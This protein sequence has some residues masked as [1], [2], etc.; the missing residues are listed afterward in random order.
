MENGT[1]N[2][3]SQGTINQGTKAG[4]IISINIFS[5][6]NRILKR[7]IAMVKKK[8]I[9]PARI[10]VSFQIILSPT[11]FIITDLTIL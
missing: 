9:M 6:A 5:H 3:A 10:N 1:L 8:S 2:G 7:L 11:P 4:S